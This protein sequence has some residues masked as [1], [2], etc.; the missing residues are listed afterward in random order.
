MKRA[1]DHATPLP[2]RALLYVVLVLYGLWSLFPILWVMLTSLK[3]PVEALRVPP[4]LV[5]EPTFANYSSVFA[6]VYDF[7]AVVMNSVLI[8]GVGTLIILVLAVPA[9]YGLSRL[10]PL[11][12]NTM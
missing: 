2:A 12:S 11:G 1:S 6:T 8:A 4:Q 5:F 3:P 9:A 10:L 7:R